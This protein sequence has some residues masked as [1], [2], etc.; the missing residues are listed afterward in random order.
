ML[1]ILMA[2]SFSLLLLILWTG[3][4]KPQRV[5]SATSESPAS[6]KFNDKAIQTSLLDPALVTRLAQLDYSA[7]LAEATS[8]EDYQQLMADSPFY[9]LQVDYKSLT[10][11]EKLLIDGWKLPSGQKGSDIISTLFRIMDFSERYSRMPDNG[12]ELALMIIQD[13]YRLTLDQFLALPRLEQLDK[14]AQSI[15]PITG[16][17]FSSLTAEEWSAG[18]IGI[19]HIDS[20]GDLMALLPQE[21]ARYYH[22]SGDFREGWRVI[23]FGA[24]PQ[25]I[26]MDRPYGVINAPKD[27]AELAAR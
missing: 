19:S 4:T 9:G 23:A 25:R 16:R 3:C 27:A 14:V 11:G 21:K 1:R 10:P 7:E 17:C 6:A 15:N 20:E 26:L 18:A 2:A 13:D 24:E 5:S 22:P 12:A 8:I